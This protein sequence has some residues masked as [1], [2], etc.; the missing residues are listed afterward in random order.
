MLSELGLHTVCQEARCPNIGGCWSDKTAAFMILGDA[1]TRCCSFCAV[2][3]AESQAITKPDN[4]EPE[5]LAKAVQ[6]MQLEYAVVTSVTRDDLPDF[7]ASQFAAVVTEIKKLTPNCRVELLI[8]DFNGSSEALST[9]LRTD[10]QV[11]NHNLE[12]VQRLYPIVRPQANYARSIN[13]L[14]M[15]KEIN[16]KVLTKCGLMVGL[17]EEK[18]ELWEVMDQL[19]DAN[20]DILTIGQYLQPGA[21]QLPVD[22]YLTPDEFTEIEEI[23]RS[24]GFKVV[25]AGPLVRSSLHACQQVKDLL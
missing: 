8:P 5:R 3:K 16:P 18:S 21:N 13:L 25:Q 12:T 15:A 7:G 22:R 2:T 6:A 19:L 24:K 9:V 10:V 4:R 1:C 14:R 23:G 20:V 11:L 17:G